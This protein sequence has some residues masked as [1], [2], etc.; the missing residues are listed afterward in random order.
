[1]FINRLVFAIALSSVGAALFA[2]APL[3]QQPAPT[4]RGD[5]PFDR[6]VFR[7]IGP[8]SPSGRV[9]DLAVLESNP[10]IFYVAGATS[11]VWKTINAGTTFTPV[12]DDQAT[13]SVG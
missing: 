2:Q 13:A 12:F 4:L 3:V 7:N 11:G 10:A 1:M 9:D 5:G 8:A 6:L